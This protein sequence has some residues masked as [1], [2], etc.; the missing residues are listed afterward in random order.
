MADKDDPKK[1]DS[2][3]AEHAIIEAR[4]NKA[5]RI[6]SRGENPFANDTVARLPGSRTLDLGAL[7]ALAEGA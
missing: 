5:A 2:A 1:T 3:S 4:R 6:R 7:R